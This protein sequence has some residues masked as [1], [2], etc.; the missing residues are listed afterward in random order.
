MITKAQYLM[1]RDILFPEDFTAEIDGNAQKTIDT[2][3]PLLDSFYADTGIRLT[4]ASGWRPPAINDTTSNAASHSWHIVAGAVDIRDTNSRD[5]ARWVAANQDQLIAAG[6]FCER[7][8]WTPDWVHFSQH[9]PASGHRFYIPSTAPAKV[10]R[11]PEQDT[12]D[13]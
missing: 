10:A 3:N 8:E 2:V 12:Y 1:G 7:F 5:L 4:V 6:L 11:L 9:P 13:C